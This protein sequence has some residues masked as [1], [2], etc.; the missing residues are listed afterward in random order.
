L[1]SEKFTILSYITNNFA[2]NIIT[3]C[4]K[5]SFLN[6]YTPIHYIFSME[7][8]KRIISDRIVFIADAHLGRRGEE[9][10]NE[11]KLASF[12]RKLNGSISYLYILG[13]LFDFWFEYRSVV[14]R[15]APRVLFELYNLVEAG[16]K[17]TLLAGNHD[18]WFGGYLRD[19]VGLNLIMND[20]VVEHQGLKLYLH[21]G[22]GLYPRDYGYR[23][24][25]RILRNKISIFL[26]S[27]IH[28]DLAHI[29]ARITSTTSR[30][31]LAPPPGRDEIYSTLFRSI[32][33]KKLSESYDAVI[34]GHSHVPLI[35]SREKGKLILLGDW[36]KHDSYVV[37]EN[38]SFSLHF[39]KRE[40]ES[41][42]LSCGKI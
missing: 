38:G 10:A 25:K 24:L 14:P 20:L 31:Y 6:I 5:N 42:F 3:D 41:A 18:Y 12:L 13:D 28:P 8:N 34:Y 2:R 11:E 37:L 33:D 16:T 23:L 19:E 32:A 22:D 15:I 35:E 39:W 29:I 4:L 36:I 40:P 30:N 9:H 27:L 1:Y 17:V 26:F 21:H 7:Q